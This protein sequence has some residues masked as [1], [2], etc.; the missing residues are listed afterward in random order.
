MKV[1]GWNGREESLSDLGWETEVTL[2]DQ[3][4]DFLSKADAAPGFRVSLF[5]K[6]FRAE[7]VDQTV[8]D[9][10]QNGLE[11]PLS[12]QPVYGK[13]IPKYPKWTYWGPTLAVLLLPLF[14][15]GTNSMCR[16][17]SLLCHIPHSV[18]VWAPPL[19][20]WWVFGRVLQVRRASSF[21]LQC[22]LH[23]HFW[24]VGIHIARATLPHLPKLKQPSCMHPFVL[25][26]CS[27][28]CLH[29]KSAETF[30]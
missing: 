1:N 24:E 19:G 3:W 18:V 8:R 14:H 27:W 6:T 29:L 22:E 15:A 13:N 30:S 21:C 7:G 5:G 11:K 16:I 10:W 23:L 26:L 2:G 17:Y 12:V 9:F 25:S 4:F 28:I 20:L